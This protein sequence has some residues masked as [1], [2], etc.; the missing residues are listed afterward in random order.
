MGISI[1]KSNEWGGLYSLWRYQTLIPMVIFCAITNRIVLC[2]QGSN[3]L[4]KEGRLGA[5]LEH[6]FKF[7]QLE[8]LTMVSYLLLQWV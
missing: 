6:L 4:G 7:K 8:K 3:E 2:S 5:L 1:S